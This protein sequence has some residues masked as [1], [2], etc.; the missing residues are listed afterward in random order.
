VTQPSIHVSPL[1]R[2]TR[3]L[4]LRLWCVHTVRGVCLAAGTAAVLGLFLAWTA[5]PVLTR[6]R[7]LWTWC[8]LGAAALAALAWVMSPARRFRGPRIA[9]VVSIADYGLSQRL[10]S[11]LELSEAPQPELAGAGRAPHVSHEL[12]HAHLKDVQEALRALPVQRVLPWSRVWRSNSVWF[13]VLTVACFAT[14][15]IEQPRVRAFVQ[16]LLAPAVERVDGTRVTQVYSQLRVHVT[17][18]SYLDREPAWFEH[19]DELTLPAGTMLKMQITPRFAVERGRLIA[20]QRFAGLTVA[21]DGVLTGQLN[22]QSDAELRIEVSQH[23]ARYEDPRALHVKITPDAA[24][25]IRVDTP[26]TGTLAPPGEVVQLRLLASDDQGIANVQL[27]ARVDGEPE[28]Q[29][30]LF[31]A[32]DEGGAQRELNSGA[33]FT[34]EE[35]GASEGDTIVLW[36]EARDTDVITG[37]HTTRSPDI[38]LEVSQPGPGLSEFIPSLQQIADGAVDVLGNRLDM[39]VV[40]DAAAARK[41]FEP[42]QRSARAWISQLDAV[43]Q[44][45]DDLH[46]APVTTDQLRGMRRRNDQLLT[47]EAALHTATP[48][49]FQERADADAHQVDELERDV[50]LLADMLAR[51]HI[52]EAKAIAEELRQLKRHIEELLTQLGKTHSPEAEKALM[53]EIARAQRRLNE[54]TQSLSRMATRVPSEFVNRDAIPKQDAESSLANLERAV[55]NHDLR[56][57]A[58][59]LDSLAKQIDEL[60]SQLGQ[61]GLRLQESRFGPHDQALAEARRKLEVLG[62]EQGRLA[63]RSGELLRNTLERGQ[64]NSA[65]ARA[66][67]LAPRADALGQLAEQLAQEAGGGYQSSAANRAAERARDARDALK[68]GDLSQARRMAQSAERSLRDAADELESQAR[69]FPSQRGA[70][71][72]R[73]ALAQKAAA[74]AESLSRGISGAMPNASG[75]LNEGER[76]RMQA[77][78]DAQRKTAEAADQLQ[79]AFDKGPDGL[80]LSPNASQGLENVQKAMRQAQRALERGNVDDA[81]REQKQA[82][83]QLQK[84]S[85]ALSEQQRGGASRRGAHSSSQQAA[86]GATPS[87]RVHIPGTEEWK[88]PTEL[89]RRLLD[90]MQES[91]PAGYEAAIKR[92]YQE[93]MR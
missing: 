67:G 44:H 81:N 12:I 60:A 11:A 29:R 26:R 50:V 57:A 34:P 48:R 19:P 46:A 75:Q 17:Y 56:Q 83:D 20:G 41:R 74:E 6:S 39:P 91:S 93:L 40:K 76:R 62:T 84:L 53:R 65:D 92:Y 2:Y 58:E 32:V 45:A 23:G 10:R 24:P 64:S 51:A 89:R 63:D 47:A 1:R 37:P 85:Q 86:S 21:P 78:A 4:S 72:E 61:G 77:D 16:A 33:D 22:V 8:A 27:H 80:P 73:A 52:D 55:Q 42:L 31:S 14:L 54:L 15:S 18:P 7:A 13:G 28:Q 82:S 30:Q 9:D 35:F 38:A 87:T 25:S 90:A 43:L 79:Q 59:H 3:H 36:V 5:E 69:V 70:A 71:A 49:S 88:S 66:Q 68:A